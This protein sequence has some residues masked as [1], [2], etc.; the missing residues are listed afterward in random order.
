MRQKYLPQIYNVRVHRTNGTR[1]LLLGQSGS[2]PRIGRVVN[3]QIGRDNT[4]IAKIVAH[5]RSPGEP[6][7][8]AE[9]QGAS[10]KL[11]R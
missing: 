10:L 11:D 5:P 4:L 1:R 8:A 9:L 2:V 7:E 3:I 6:V